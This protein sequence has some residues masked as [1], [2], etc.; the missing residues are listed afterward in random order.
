MTTTN[1]NVVGY[2]AYFELLHKEVP[3]RTTQILITPE[4]MTSSHV[5]VPMVMY[6]RRLTNAAPK[7]QWR[8]SSSSLTLHTMEK[9]ERVASQLR[10][11]NDYLESLSRGSWK[12]YKEPI[13]V[14]ITPEDLEDVRSARTPYKILGRVWKTRKFLGFPE[15]FL[16]DKSWSA[17]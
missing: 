3:F 11:A 8:R 17:S 7:K 15:V 10:I 6:S 13:I 1:A 2:A 16:Q 5:Q 12:L 14:E 4:G 9:A